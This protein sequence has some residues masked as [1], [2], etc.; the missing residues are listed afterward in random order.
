MSRVIEKKLFSS[1]SSNPPINFEHHTNPNAWG[2]SRY[3]TLNGKRAFELSFPCDTCQFVFER[4]EGANKA[5][6][7][8]ELSESLRKGISQL[9]DQMNK[10]ITL[11]SFLAVNECIAHEPEIDI[12]FKILH[13]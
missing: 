7:I 11:L 1:S 2:F 10:P 12:A 4:M 5:I 6:S 8:K 13:G 9:E 3:L